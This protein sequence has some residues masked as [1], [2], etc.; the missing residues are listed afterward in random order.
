[1]KLLPLQNQRK[2]PD[3]YR[4]N[5]VQYRSCS[6]TYLFGNADPSEIEERNTQY[7]A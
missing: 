2:H 6:S 5:A 4:P 1:M 3:E 7:N